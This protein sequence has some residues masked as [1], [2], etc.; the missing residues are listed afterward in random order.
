[1]KRSTAV[2]QLPTFLRVACDHKYDQ[3]DMEKEFTFN[4][5]SDYHM[6]KNA[7][8][9]AK[10]PYFII[11]RSLLKVENAGMAAELFVFEQYRSPLS[12]S[13]R[14]NNNQTKVQCIS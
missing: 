4:K 7:I 14:S 5:I 13:P 1:L 11:Y 3:C 9:L 12:Y 6:I 10:I 2:Y 8:S